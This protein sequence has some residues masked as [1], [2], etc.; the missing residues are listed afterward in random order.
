MKKSISFLVIAMAL[1][2]G[3]AQ[4]ST[5]L[6]LRG[7]AARS[8][9]DAFQVPGD[10]DGGYITRKTGDGKLLCQVGATFGAPPSYNCSFENDLWVGGNAAQTAYDAYSVRGVHD[11]GYFTRKSA[12]GTLTCQVLAP[13]NAPA[14]YS[15]DFRD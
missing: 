9:Y 7:N 1:A 14:S 11:G 3:A 4:A 2:A 15:C 8:F 12:E 10:H 13:F 5:L 6:S